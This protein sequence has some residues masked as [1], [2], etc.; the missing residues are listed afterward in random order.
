MMTRAIA[1]QLG[2]AMARA[3]ERAG[4]AVICDRTISYLSH[5]L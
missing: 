4:R 1:L 2:G 5:E 3:F